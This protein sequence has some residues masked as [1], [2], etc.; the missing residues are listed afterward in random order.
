MSRSKRYVY[1][2]PVDGGAIGAHLARGPQIQDGELLLSIGIFT[3][4]AIAFNAG[5]TIDV[6]TPTAPS[7]IVAGLDPANLSAPGNVYSGSVFYL[8]YF[9]H[10]GTPE[11]LLVTVNGADLT[12]G[13]LE[14][15]FEAIE[16]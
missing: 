7:F 10:F 9:I 3:S 4:S 11:P 8:F 16:L 2:I 12:A 13:V 6:G 15:L 1:S 14:F 5:C